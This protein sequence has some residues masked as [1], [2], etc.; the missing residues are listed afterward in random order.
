MPVKRKPAY[1]LHKPTGQARVRFRKRDIYLG[2]YGSPESRDRYDEVL[3][4]WFAENNCDSV[5]LTIDELC[6]RFMKHAQEY[7]RAKDG[8]STGEA[9]LVRSALRPL[10]HL[11][12]TTRARDFG[13]KKLKAVREEMIR[14]GRVRTSINAQ[15]HRIRRAFRWAA[16]EELLPEPVYASLRTVQALKQGRC[17]AKE[18]VPVSPVDQEV[19]DNTLPH[20]GAVAQAMVQLQLLSGARPGEITKLRPCDVSFGVDGVW[21][22][23]PNGHKTAHRG[24]DRRIFFGPR[25]QEIL[26]PFLNRAPESYCFSPR[27]AN[28]RRWAEQH[29]KRVTPPNQGNR[30]GSSYE[31]NPKR[32][33][34][35]RYTKDSYA[36]TVARACRKAGVDPWTPNQLRHSRA[37]TLRKMYGVESAAVVL[38]H[39]DP[40]TTLIYAEADYEK[41]K[42]IMRSVG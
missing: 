27:E 1:L 10:V 17:K 8:S 31:A 38:G 36:R 19:V 34:G 29:A 32:P 13:P 41:A 9:E 42:D 40:N 11:Y 7:Y 20:L 12:G 35:H 30:P 28:Q 37:T 14:A 21:C 39:S 24:K 25:C 6:I 33:P 16:E 3:A 26:R 5:T 2:K 18:S 22:Y 4:E 15:V 23:R